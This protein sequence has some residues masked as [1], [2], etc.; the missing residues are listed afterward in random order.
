MRCY[1]IQGPGARRYASTAATARTTRE[2]VMALTKAKKS[3]VS[4]EDAEVPTAKPDLLAF[5][6]GLCK[7][8]DDATA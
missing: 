4:I 5:I 1:V 3:E 2:E 6:N 8:L 7:E